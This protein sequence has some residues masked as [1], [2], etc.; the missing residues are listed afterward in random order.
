M[1]RPAP[2][3]TL[4]TLR[5][6]GISIASI[7]TLCVLPFI[8]NYSV[9]AGWWRWDDPSILL[10]I[11]R[12]SFWQDFL[13][14]EVWQ[15]FSPSNLTPWLSF[16]I[17]ADLILFG[18]N[19]ALFYTH[20]LFSLGAAAVALFFVL[21]L[22]VQA[23]FALLGSC[24]FLIG[25]PSLVVAQQLMTRHYIEGAIFC[26]VGLLFFVQ[27][28]RN[29]RLAFLF[30]SALAY[31]LAVTAKE[32]YVP[33]VI[34]L[35]FLPERT[36]PER[37][38][39]L[40]PHLIIAACYTIWRGYM[41]GSLG[42]GYTASGNL[43]SSI[44]LTEIV[45]TFSN[46]PVLLFGPLW[47]LAVVLYLSLIVC[48][49]YFTGSRLVVTLLVALLILLPMVPLVSFP[50]INI[51]DRYLFLPW[52]GFSFSVAY[53]SAQIHLALIE[54]GKVQTSRLVYPLLVILFLVSL[55]PAVS[56]QSTV[57]RF[58]REF[59][60]HGEFIWQ[61]D[62][63]VAFIPSGILLASYWYVTGLVQ[64]KQRLTGELAPNPTIDPALGNASA[65][66]VWTY[67]SSCACLR[68]SGTSL[69]ELREQSL[70]SIDRSAPL[71]LS[72]QYGSG[73]FE[74]QFGP[75]TNGQYHV[76][77]EQL[78]LLPAPQSGRLRVDIEPQTTF[79]LR[80]TA[81]EGWL[82]YS[83]PQLISPDM[84]RVFWERN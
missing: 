52:L 47:I 30:I 15:E 55:I 7:A 73:Y 61:R 84:Q 60:A 46:F 45:S 17:E 31:V 80:Y 29:P 66:E 1:T 37:I 67:D 54:S 22:W 78:G 20:Q 21:R 72:F 82:T 11:H 57:E 83:E 41:L 56:L 12:Y 49:I 28:L 44:S 50:G 69:A 13:V 65:V 64:F 16:S 68:N 63:N 70:A 75:Y 24:L 19:S 38:K 34:L 33:L 35:V 9:F 51:A 71:S 76:V 39:A 4:F 58:G 62:Q 6:S 8:L 79:Y 26:L 43:L 27:H 2:T 3:Q 42:G 74:W 18:L 5:A 14:A 48:Y 36:F 59:D 25:A 10:H 40:I 32:V 23:Q 77:S 53:F 81:P